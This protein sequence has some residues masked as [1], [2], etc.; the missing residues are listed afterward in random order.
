[1]QITF[2]A[3]AVAA[4]TW[5]ET[6]VAGHFSDNGFVDVDDDVV[7]VAVAGLGGADGRVWALQP[8]S[9]RFLALPGTNSVYFESTED[10]TADDLRA[11]LSITSL[12]DVYN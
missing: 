3:A 4:H 9:C 2:S 8:T 10:A 1:M 5:L 12:Y 6:T 11:T 7:A